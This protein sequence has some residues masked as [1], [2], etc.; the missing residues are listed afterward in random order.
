MINHCRVPQISSDSVDPPKPVLYRGWSMYPTLKFF[1]LLEIA[2][3]RNRGIRKGD[4]IVFQIPGSNNKASHRVVSFDHRGIRTRGDNNYTFD[5]WV[6]FPDDIVGQVVY[7]Q[8]GKKR[9]PVCGGL[10][11]HMYSC[12]L[13]LPMIINAIFRSLFRSSYLHLAASGFL[14]KYIPIKFKLKVLSYKRPSGVEFQLFI[15]KRSIGYRAPGQ[16]YWT[17]RAPFRLFIDETK[18]PC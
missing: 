15:G 2:P 5:S 14:R 6:I 9:V 13:R 10:I 8:R 17:I 3:Y 11:G 16:N 18:L 7:A 4:V 1:D 12:V